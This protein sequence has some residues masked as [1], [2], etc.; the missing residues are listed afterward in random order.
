MQATYRLKVSEI[1]DDLVTT[2][3]EQFK[4]EDVVE[5]T[6]RSDEPVKASDLI[7]KFLELEKK[8][9][10]KRVPVDMDFNTIVDDINI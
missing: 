10:P 8:Y 4:E 3:K 1:K 2:I 6:V 7:E 9:P 5:I